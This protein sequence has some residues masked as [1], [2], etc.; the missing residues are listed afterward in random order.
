MSLV[1]LDLGGP[2][3]FGTNTV[4][5]RSF[6]IDCQVIARQTGGWAYKGSTLVVKVPVC[7]GNESPEVAVAIN[8]VVGGLEKDR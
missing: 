7:I 5:V 8:R 6:L 1:V 3:G 4:D 2:G